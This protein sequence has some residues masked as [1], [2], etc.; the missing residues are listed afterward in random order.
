VEK[1][2]GTNLYW[3]AVTHH[4]TEHPHVHMVIR[5]VASTGEPLHFNREYVNHG[6]RGIA[7]EMCTRQLGYRTSRDALEAERQ[8][9]RERRFTS[10]PF[11]PVDAAVVLSPDQVKEIVG[12]DL[13][14]QR[15]ARTDERK[16]KVFEM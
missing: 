4:N 8:E 16:G 9:I 1:D 12:V 2:F 11:N 7:E 5:G 14:L 6:I 13:A 15:L 3:V 10:G